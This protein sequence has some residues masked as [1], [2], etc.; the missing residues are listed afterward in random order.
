[1]YDDSTTR[2]CSLYRRIF[3]SGTGSVQEDD[4]Q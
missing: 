4:A 3:I 1:M 2:H